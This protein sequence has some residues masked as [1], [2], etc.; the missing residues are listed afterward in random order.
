MKMVIPALLPVRLNRG[1]WGS[2]ANFHKAQCI[3]V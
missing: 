1:K 3:F 2:E